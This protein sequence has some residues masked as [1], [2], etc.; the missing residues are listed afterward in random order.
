[1]V[2]RQNDK[3]SLV[4]QCPNCGRLSLST[5]RETENIIYGSGKDATEIPVEL[6]VRTCGECGF[7]YTDEEAEDIRHDAVC[8]HL[9]LMTPAEIVALRKRYSMTRAEFAN[10]TRFG[11]ASL[12]RWETGQLMQNAA[13]D[14]LLYLLSFESNVARLQK[15]QAEKTQNGPRADVALACEVRFSHLTDV[16]AAQYDARSFSLRGPFLM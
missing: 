10:L 7:Q 6:P 13:N 14:Q 5:V 12:A 15:R 1:M 9:G 2:E 11:E 16:M 8:R 3:S 4:L